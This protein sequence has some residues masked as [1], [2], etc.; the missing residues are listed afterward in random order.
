LDDSKLVDGLAGDRAVFK[1]RGESE[2]PF[3]LR[4]KRLVF[5]FDV[6]ASMTRFNGH[7]G[8]LTR[9][10]ECAVMIMEALKGLEHK[11]QYKLVGHSGMTS[12][13]LTG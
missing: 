8:R 13:L 5:S 6:S 2:D 1:L 9:S 12:V 3:Q 4:P 10:L 11:F 7:D